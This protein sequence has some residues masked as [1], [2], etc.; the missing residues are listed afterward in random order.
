MALQFNYTTG[1]YSNEEGYTPE[2]PV[3]RVSTLG[4]P[5][6]LDAAEAEMLRRKRE[7]EDKRRAE[8][9]KQSAQQAK[10]GGGDD[11]PFVADSFGGGL[12][13]LVKAPLNALA[14]IPTDIVDL[15]L[16]AVD[17]AKGLADRFGN[18]VGSGGESLDV[19]GIA[20]SVQSGNT[21][22]LIDAIGQGW[23]D[24]FKYYD[25][26]DNRLTQWR[27]QHFG[28]FESG[29]GQLLGTTLRALTAIVSFPKLGARGLAIGGKVLS[30]ASKG[31]DVADAFKAVSGIDDFLKPF[32]A[33][34][35]E[36]GAA[37]IAPEAAKSA[38]NLGRQVAGNPAMYGRYE[39]IA[40]AAIKNPEIKPLVAWMDDLKGGIKDTFGAVRTP[41]NFRGPD[42]IATAVGWDAFVAFN[43][44]GEGNSFNDETLSDYIM[45]Q[46]G[47]RSLHAYA[48]PFST[49]I[50]DSSIDRKIKQM[51]EGTVLNLGISS[52]IGQFKAWKFASEFKKA[53]PAEKTLILSK[54]DSQAEGIGADIAK[55]FLPPE[56]IPKGWGNDELMAD[57]LRRGGD[58]ADAA[59]PVI[60]LEKG[61]PNLEMIQELSSMGFT[62][63][64]MYRPTTNELAGMTQFIRDAQARRVKLQAEDAKIR[65]DLRLQG[66][67]EAWFEEQVKAL[68]R[69]PEAVG[70]VQ[71]APVKGGVSYTREQLDAI[72]AGP[73]TFGTV[74]EPKE[75]VANPGMPGVRIPPGAIEKVD[76]VPT[77]IEPYSPIEPV[78]VVELPTVRRPVTPVPSPEV[79]RRSVEEQYRQAQ[80]AGTLT[81]MVEGPDGVMRNAVQQEIL[82]S[83]KSLMPKSAADLMDYAMANPMMVNAEGVA[84]AITSTI[85]NIAIRRGMAEGW[86]T[87]G[88]DLQPRFARA[89]AVDFD[90]AALQFEEAG[91]IDD[92]L[93]IQAFDIDVDESLKAANQEGAASS[94]DVAAA[95]GI[96]EVPISQT[97][98]MDLAN[99]E[100]GAQAQDVQ[101]AAIG[102]ANTAALQQSQLDAA[103][104]GRLMEAATAPPAPL[105]DEEAVR[106]F[107]GY[108]I[109]ALPAATVERQG[110]RR[111][112]VLDDEGDVIGQAG[113]QADAQIIAD[114]QNRLNREQA[115]A[116]ARVMAS[117]NIGQ[118]A[119]TVVS[120]APTG[121]TDLIS[122]MVITRP[123][124]R[125]LSGLSPEL[126]EQ[127]AASRFVRPDTPAF[128]NVNDVKPEPNQSSIRLSQAGMIELRDGLRAVIASGEVSG[129]QL[130]ML[131]RMANKFDNE[132]TL[133]EPRARAE[134]YT[135]KLIDENARLMSYGKNCTPF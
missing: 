44:A 65:E 36:L 68:E 38:V 10:E 131:K 69:G 48:S 39:A 80:M 126:D 52:L 64:Q 46:P 33:L 58:V 132:I 98:T 75:L 88:D 9:E 90:K 15:G 70:A 74:G 87:I 42:S 76:D 107:L 82:T 73:G 37:K 5:D 61:Y 14:A 123:Q 105:S 106:Q 45:T 93:Q 118:P 66:I 119:P 113:K 60:P 122:S 31:D 111:Y 30:A 85:R 29:G 17:V 1:L 18:Y 3:E 20:S 50:E 62:P 125:A 112:V 12:M 34:Q 81:D 43:M 110:A 7:A 63:Q 128:Y 13:D 21:A 94:A 130:S 109:D 24:T 72:E 6:D 27:E 135:Q 11:R 32:K 97:Q 28:N 49:R 117:D 8:L 19:G 79:I 114:K 4:L 71:E 55:S 91:N 102:D 53:S 100:M 129:S 41:S 83:I 103:E 54:F 25:D 40:K 47:L 108:D 127:L 35:A 59:A 86:V 115:I 121:S 99:A 67:D 2:V 134:L 77:G 56:P 92:A 120:G 26:A 22:P 104:E 57:W 51:G 101:G 96:T 84:D 124:A 116:R 16:G 95:E 23:Q 78:T 89:A 133:L